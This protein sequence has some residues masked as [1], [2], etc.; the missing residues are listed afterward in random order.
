MCKLFIL[1][2]AM[3]FLNPCS[4]ARFLCVWSIGCSFLVVGTL[5][6]L[7]DSTLNFLFCI[8]RGL[9]TGQELDDPLILIHE[10][11]I[12][13]LTAVVKVLELALKVLLVNAISISSFVIIIN[14]FNCAFAETKTFV[15]SF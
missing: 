1:I 8:F 11:K 7:K 10:K 5:F 4:D 13:N 2:K 15:D 12:S 14:Q 3:S 9:I 6:I